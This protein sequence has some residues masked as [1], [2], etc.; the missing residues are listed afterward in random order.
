MKASDKL[1]NTRE[2]LKANCYN[3]IPS[4]LDGYNAILNDEQTWHML[5]ELAVF[6]AKYVNKYPGLSAYFNRLTDTTDILFN[7]DNMVVMFTNLCDGK[8]YGVEFVKDFIKHVL[9][10]ASKIYDIMS[11]DSIKSLATRY[12]DILINQLDE[13]NVSTE[14]VNAITVAVCPKLQISATSMN[15]LLTLL[16][17]NKF[18]KLALNDYRNTVG[19]DLVATSD[20]I[21]DV[22]ENNTNI[23]DDIIDIDDS[24]IPEIMYSKAATESSEVSSELYEA[25]KNILTS[26]ENSCEYDPVLTEHH[27]GVL[28]ESCRDNISQIYIRE[29]DKSVIIYTDDI[30]KYILC[31][32][33]GADGSMI[34]GFS[35]D[36][37]KDDIEISTPTN[38]ENYLKGDIELD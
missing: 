20:S 29:A 9:L 8:D 18:D 31:E 25:V 21:A 14:L 23:L 10:T 35:I 33:T 12:L 4:V 30:S 2:Y 15:T 26:I 22:G 13:S 32:K 1:P 16:F 34:Y 11:G 27:A 17:P 6:K 24:S 7:I 37:S 5:P 38:Y 19:K 28:L 3:F 36:S